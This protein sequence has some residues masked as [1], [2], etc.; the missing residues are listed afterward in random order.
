MKGEYKVNF[1]V[2]KIEKCR[3]A[4]MRQVGPYG[5]N[6]IQLMENIKTWAKEHQLLDESAVIL[7][8]TQDNPTATLPQKCRYDVCIIIQDDYQLDGSIDETELMSGDYAV[9]KVKHT[10]EDIQK[11]WEYIFSDLHYSGYQVANQPII[12]RYTQQMIANH[13]CEICVPIQTI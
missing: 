4:Y 11:A 1:K 13:Y 10:A 7:G 12:E 3:V 6:N 8:I 2:E 5:V 9:Y